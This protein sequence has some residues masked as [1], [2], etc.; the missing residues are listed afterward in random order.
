MLLSVSS[1]CSIKR[2]TRRARLSP[3]SSSASSR[4]RLTRVKA[5]SAIASTPENAHRRATTTIATT[6]IA[7]ASPPGGRYLG[8]EQTQMSCA[9]LRVAEAGQQLLL[10]AAHRGCLVGLRVVVVEQMEHAVNHE[11]RDLFLGGNA[12]L[13]S[14]AGG[15]RGTEDHV[16]EQ[17]RRIATLCR[18]AG[19]AAALVGL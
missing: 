10:A 3:S 12:T 18:R 6:F 5:V 2:S 4:M 1:G 8:A 15:D 9:R 19:T 17:R 16:A 7:R 14:L 11:Q 13:G